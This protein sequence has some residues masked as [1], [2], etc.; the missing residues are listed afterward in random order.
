MHQYSYAAWGYGK[1]F[2]LNIRG[3][4]YRKGGRWIKKH[5]LDLTNISALWEKYGC[6]QLDYVHIYAAYKL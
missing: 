1:V 6:W 4:I 3:L 2:Y 5:A